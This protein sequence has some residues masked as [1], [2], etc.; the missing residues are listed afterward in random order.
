MQLDTSQYFA[1][2]LFIMNDK[3]A[4]NLWDWEKNVLPNL[5]PTY[6]KPKLT[7][8]QIVTYTEYVCNR[9]GFDI[10]N[11]SFKKARKD[12]I[13]DIGV[14]NAANWKINFFGAKIT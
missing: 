14:Y 3:Q 5:I 12:S 8:L 7:K 13:A 9:L 2:G 4:D 11:F 10:P 1:V 6:H